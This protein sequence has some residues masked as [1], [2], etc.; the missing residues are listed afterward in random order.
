[1]PLRLWLCNSFFYRGYSS[2]SEGNAIEAMAMIPHSAMTSKRKNTANIAVASRKP[3]VFSA[4]A[5]AFP[6]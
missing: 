1:M 5:V 6:F 3:R 2:E 4:T